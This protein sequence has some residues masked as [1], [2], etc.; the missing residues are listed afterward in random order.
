MFISNKSNKIQGTSNRY[1]CVRFYGLFTM[2][3]IQNISEA[4]LLKISLFGLCD[5]EIENAPV[6][7]SNE[8]VADRFRCF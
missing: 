7:Q 5:R 8:F 6:D 2:A 1:K 4:E 3:I